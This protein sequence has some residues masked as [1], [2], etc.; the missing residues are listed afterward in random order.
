MIIV[1]TSKWLFDSMKEIGH[2][3]RN[4]K[5]CALPLKMVWAAFWEAADE[6]AHWRSAGG[7]PGCKQ[8][9]KYSWE[10][11][12]CFCTQGFS[13]RNHDE[14]SMTDFTAQQPSGAALTETVQA[15]ADNTQSGWPSLIYVFQ[16]RRP[17]SD[18]GSVMVHL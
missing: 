14:P 6:E 15:T 3:Q 1:N 11:R 5:N 10:A 16:S 17:G 12:V 8:G 7:K 2:A 9:C 18:S 4:P 13:G